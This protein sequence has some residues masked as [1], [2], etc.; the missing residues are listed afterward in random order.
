M[1]DT[2]IACTRAQD[3]E[4]LDWLDGSAWHNGTWTEFSS[5][6][7]SRPWVLLL[8]GARVTLLETQLPVRDLTTARRAAPFAG[9]FLCGMVAMALASSSCDGESS[10][11]TGDSCG[12]AG[13]PPVEGTIQASGNAR[14]V[15]GCR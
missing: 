2:V 8:D 3:E 1:S 12:E 9:S 6:L 15:R 10:T 14:R 4:R 11:C 5:A 7:G 13:A